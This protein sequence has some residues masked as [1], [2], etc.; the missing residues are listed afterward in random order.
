MAKN[1]TTSTSRQELDPAAQQYLAP[2][3]AKANTA[4]S[5]TGPQVAPVVGFTPEQ[6]AA[7]AA[8]FTRGAMGSPTVGAANQYA[9][10]VIGGQ[11]LNSNPWLGDAARLAA[12]GADSAANRAGRFGSGAHLDTRLQ[13]ISPILASAYQ[14]ERGL[15]QGMAQFAPTLAGQ[16]YTDIAAMNQVGDVRQGLAQ[17]IANQQTQV[18]N[19]PYDN[20]QQMLRLIYGVPGGQ[21]STSQPGPSG[22]N[23]GLGALFSGLGLAAGFL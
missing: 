13:A 23:T 15:Q 14:G 6:Q 9:Q 22:L 21:T 17:Q 1:D 20:I 7:Q 11:Y 18:A 2:W 8:Q 3:L 4:Y 19:Q 16:D 5:G 10:N 12:T